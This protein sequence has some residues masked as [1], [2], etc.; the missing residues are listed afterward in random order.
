[1]ARSKTETRRSACG[2]GSA[3]SS[4]PFTT[5][6]IAVVAPMPSASVATATTLN[7]GVRA[8]DRAANRMS[9]NDVVD[10]RGRRETA[11][12]PHMVCHARDGAEVT[13][14]FGARASRRHSLRDERG[15]LHLDVKAHFVVDVRVE[16]AAADDVAQAAKDLSRREHV[17]SQTA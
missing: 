3:R 14:R 7:A 4:T 8:S 9:R 16:A 1:M 6:N 11:R 5:L 2:Y 17:G 12:L 13:L 10:E 15:R